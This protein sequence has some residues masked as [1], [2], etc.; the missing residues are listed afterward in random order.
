MPD[1]VRYRWIDGP[2]ATDA[3]WSRIDEILATR[4][5]SSLNRQTSRIRVA[6]EETSG[7]LLG[8]L[9]LQL[10]PHVEPLFVA[11]SARGSGIAERLADDMVKFLG[12]VQVRGF[13]LTADSPHAV[14][15]AKDRGL[16]KVDAPV[17]RT[18]Q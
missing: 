15:L 10:F 8:F 1:E 4:G 9:V 12:E 11:P 2:T 3:E 7:K 14:K 16:M 6:E 18:V 13:E 5:W 17:Y